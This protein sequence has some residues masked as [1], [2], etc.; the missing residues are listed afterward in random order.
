M[1]RKSIVLYSSW[2]DIFASLP[3]E[4]A[5]T[6]IKAICEYAYE[7]KEPEIENPAIYA[8]FDMIRKKL[9]KDH[10]AY[11]E[12]V[13]RLKKNSSSKSN[14]N[15]DDIDTKSS[16]SRTEIEPIST[17][18][19]DDIESDTVTDTVTVPISKDIG[20]VGKR[21][22]AFRPPDVSEVRAYCQERNNKVDPEKFV[23]FYTSKGWFV[24]K[25]KM[26]DWRAAVRNWEKDETA[27][28]GTT[29]KSARP[30]YIRSDYDF[31]AIE[32][33]LVRNG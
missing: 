31:D 23:N 19:R 21:A 20:V 7:D 5:G 16:P 9:D 25:N 6:L 18:N 32:R 13:A 1:T 15:R 8:I 11:E 2:G 26:K 12:K 33:T 28:S 22:S 30:N 29:I 27:R 14:R 17:R 10:T 24:G 3:E 4:Q